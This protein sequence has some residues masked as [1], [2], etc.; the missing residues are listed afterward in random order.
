EDDPDVPLPE[1]AEAALSILERTAALVARDRRAIRPLVARAE[2]NR[3]FLRRV[4]EF[5]RDVHD[6]EGLARVERHV[7]GAAPEPVGAATP[8]TA[9]DA[10]G[11]EAG[12]SMRTG[13]EDA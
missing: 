8:E 11:S 1:A 6:L 13:A 2:Q 3:Y 10:A 4:P 9:Q 7:F 5:S 12:G